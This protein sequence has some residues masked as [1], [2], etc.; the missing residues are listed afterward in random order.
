MASVVGLLLIVGAITAYLVNSG[1]LEDRLR[2]EAQST[3]IRLVPEPYEATVE[4]TEVAFSWPPTF[5]VRYSGFEVAAPQTQTVV[6][7]AQTLEV[8]LDPVASIRANGRPVFSAIDIEDMTFDVQALP[9]AGPGIVPVPAAL[10]DIPDIV[11]AVSDGV[12][13]L[14]DRLG[15]AD[16][17]G[18]SQNDIAVSAQDIRIA[19]PP[20]VYTDTINIVE[21][22]S[23][24]SGS[25][26]E[27]TADLQIAGQTSGLSLRAT[28]G[29]DATDMRVDLRQAV[30]PAR[31]L[32]TFLSNNMD[33]H[34][35]DASPEP[36]LV[37]LTIQARTARSDLA[38][39]AL[40][41]TLTPRDLQLK[42]A[43]GDFV[44]VNGTADLSFDFADNT[45]TW[46]RG[47]WT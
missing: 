12:G 26:L 24:V 19:L 3:L 23:I 2:Q 33:D 20:N 38:R 29:A 5:V 28:R 10:R 14:I 7:K 15:A 25:R 22:S 40:T 46:A 13:G 27:T 9:Q 41:A 44:P 8:A 47:V 4:S 11:T 45:I 18:G 42:L 6:V 36:V 32:R 39:D 21:A 1:A 30:F 17:D 16:D 43:D 35:P 31:R 37:D 34:E